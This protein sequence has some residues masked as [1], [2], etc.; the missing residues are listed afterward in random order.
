MTEQ[1]RRRRVNVDGVFV[2]GI[3]ALCVWGTVALIVIT[4]LATS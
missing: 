1:H 2:G 3:L 4:A